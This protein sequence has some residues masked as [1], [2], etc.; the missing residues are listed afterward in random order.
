MASAYEMAE[1]LRSISIEL[2]YSNSLNKNKAV[3]IDMNQK[4]LYDEG[5]RADGTPTG[6]YAPST[7]KQKERKGQRTD[8]VTGFDKGDMYKDMFVEQRDNGDFIMGST[9]PETKY[10]GE[11]FAPSFGLTDANEAIL[12]NEYILPEMVHSIADK[13][14]LGYGL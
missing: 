9:A 11:K 10:F 4:Q 14:G 3:A 12:A 7:K 1:R 13:T 2:E 6:F 5:I 8:H